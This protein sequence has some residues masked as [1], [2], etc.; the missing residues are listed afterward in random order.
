MWPLDSANTDSV[1][2]HVQVKTCLPQGTTARSR[3]RMPV[4][5]PP[6]VAEIHDVLWVTKASIPESC[7]P[8][9]GG[10]NEQINATTRE[11][12]AEPRPCPLD[13][14]ARTEQHWPGRPLEQIGERY[15]RV[16]ETSGLARCGKWDES[17]RC[18]RQRPNVDVHAGLDA[19]LGEPEDDEL[20]VVRVSAEDAWS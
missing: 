13:G 17:F 5:S 20:A 14:G 1:G 3:M 2:Q 19:L 12:V 11:P 18:H 15:A 9:Q 10:T 7:L 8:C 16:G 6:T 4:M